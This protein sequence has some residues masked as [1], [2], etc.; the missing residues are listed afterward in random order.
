MA[1]D[2]DMA[3]WFADKFRQPGGIFNGFTFVRKQLVPSSAGHKRLRICPSAE[4]SWGDAENITGLLLGKA[5]INGFFY[6][7]NHGF[8]KLFLK[9]AF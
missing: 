5:F 3:Y 4:L 8:F 1:A 6:N 2:E 9:M 7:I